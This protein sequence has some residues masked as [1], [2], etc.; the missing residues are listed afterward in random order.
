MK[1]GYVIS[2][3]FGK[4]TSYHT[5]YISD[6]LYYVKIHL[7]HISK[8]N[9]T[10]EKI[11]IVCTYDDSVDKNEIWNAL[12]ELIR[13]YD[14]IILFQRDN[15]GG[16]YCSWYRALEIDNGLCDYVILE[17]DD[18]TIYDKNSVEY[19]LQYF[20]EQPDLLY[21]CKYWTN[22]PYPVNNITVPNH[23]AMSGGMLNNTLYQELKSNEIDFTLDYGITK[24]SIFNNQ[25]LFL[26][27]Y[28]KNG[29]LIMDFKDK[30]SA[31]FAHT[32]T[33]VEE[34]GNPN[35]IRLFIPITNKYF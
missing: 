32:N 3:Y 8:L 11:Y 24:H 31:L 25:A 33:N 17:E 23:A 2:A 4:R 28:R 20:I 9:T 26:E 1:V 27:Q 15:T 10:F 21:L 34:F 35:G 30:Y 6:K 12:Y 22:N 19:M 18:Y 29:N 16:S 5:Q 13:P 7:E 14:N